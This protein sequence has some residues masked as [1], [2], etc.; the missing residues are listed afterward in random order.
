MFPTIAV[1]GRRPVTLRTSRLSITVCGHTASHG[2]QTHGRDLAAVPA[3]NP[4]RS[5]ESMLTQK[6][7]ATIK[8]HCILPVRP[9]CLF[10]PMFCPGVNVEMSI[11]PSVWW[12]VTEMIFLMSHKQQG[13]RIQKGYMELKTSPSGFIPPVRPGKRAVKK[14]HL[15]L[16]LSPHFGQ[17]QRAAVANKNISMSS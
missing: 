14:T 15:W 6:P 4:C 3:E 13:G 17:Q 12:Q 9:Q 5:R 2:L 10:S 8:T 16:S 11:S 1:L 7:A